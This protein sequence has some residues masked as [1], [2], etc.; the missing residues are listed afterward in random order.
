[1][2][3]II[4]VDLMQLRLKHLQLTYWSSSL[5]SVVMRMKVVAK[6]VDAPCEIDLPIN[7][8]SPTE[9]YHEILKLTN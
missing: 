6:F 3:A 4:G 8:V 5:P 9:V 2:L 7:L 1:M